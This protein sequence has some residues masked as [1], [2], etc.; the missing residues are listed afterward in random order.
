MNAARIWIAVNNLHEVSHWTQQTFGQNFNPKCFFNQWN[1]FR[2][3]EE[4]FA[5]LNF[6]KNNEWFHKKISGGSFNVTTVDNR[7][8]VNWM[9]EKSRMCPLTKWQQSKCSIFL[10]RPLQTGKLLE[11]WKVFLFLFHWLKW[12][13]KTY[14][15]IRGLFSSLDLDTDIISWSL[16]IDN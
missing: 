8:N 1:C 10:N 11:Q 6:R 9:S 3:V 14:I 7:I 4:C 2:R 5:S 12:Q 16:F 15:L 13:K